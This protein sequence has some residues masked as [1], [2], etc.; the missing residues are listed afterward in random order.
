MCLYLNIHNKYTQHTYIYYVNQ[1][2]YFIWI[3]WQQLSE[4]ERLY[5]HFSSVHNETKDH[6]AT[7]DNTVLHKKTIKWS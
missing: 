4:S 1:N 3:I 7:Q 5:Y 6:G 2:L